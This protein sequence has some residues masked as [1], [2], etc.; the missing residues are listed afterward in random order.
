MYS[1]SSTYVELESLCECEDDSERGGSSI[2][3]R[4]LFNFLGP[5]LTRN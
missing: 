5:E 1:Y 2:R 3:I 4:S